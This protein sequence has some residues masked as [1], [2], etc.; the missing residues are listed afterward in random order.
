MFYFINNIPVKKNMYS[1]KYHEQN[2]Q[3]QTRQAEK[4]DDQCGDKIDRDREFEYSADQVDNEKHY[5]TQKSVQQDFENQSDRFFNY[6]EK[7]YK[8]ESDNN[9]GNGNHHVHTPRFRD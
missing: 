4:A 6:F 5:K 2:E 8:D 7:Y 3:D 9:Q 1:E